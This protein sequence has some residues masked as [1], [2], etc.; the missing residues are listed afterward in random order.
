MQNPPDRLLSAED[1]ADRLALSIRTLWRRLAEGLVPAPVVRDN[2][3]YTRW[4][5]SDI[6]AYIKDL[7]PQN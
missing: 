2:K 7:A 4:R 5:E 3:K 6:A 1:V